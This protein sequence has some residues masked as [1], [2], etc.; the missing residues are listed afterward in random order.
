MDLKF[1]TL[2]SISRAETEPVNNSALLGNA[3]IAET[4]SVLNDSA[5]QSEIDDVSILSVGDIV[6]GL[7]HGDMNDG[8]RGDIHKEVNG[9]FG[10]NNPVGGL[11]IGD[12]GQIDLGSIPVPG[13]IGSAGDL[14]DWAKGQM[15]PNRVDMGSSGGDPLGQSHGSRDM[16]G[17]INVNGGGGEGLNTESRDGHWVGQLRHGETIQYKD[18]TGFGGMATEGSILVFKPGM[19]AVYKDTNDKGVV[20]R[21]DS[22]MVN[23]DNSIDVVR[24]NSQTGAVEKVTHVPPPPQEPNSSEGEGEGGGGIDGGNDPMVQ[25]NSSTGGY[26]GDL[27]QFISISASARVAAMAKPIHHLT[28][29]LTPSALF[30]RPA[31]VPMRVVKAKVPMAIAMA[32]R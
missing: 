20:V 27:G 28:I 24:T 25:G 23:A 13:R 11:D 26:Q 7:G 8:Q 19:V 17:N 16:P 3:T 4:G 5:L 2:V 12:A 31:R 21:Q 32:H 9:E 18:S 22:L 14:N 6:A 30:R 15:D 10:Q 1:N 29:S